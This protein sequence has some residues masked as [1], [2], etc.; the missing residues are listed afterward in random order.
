M[1]TSTAKSL[2][3]SQSTGP[4]VSPSAIS[5]SLIGPVRLSRKVQAKVRM[6]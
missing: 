2:N 1:P 4:A 6:M 3:S 5:A